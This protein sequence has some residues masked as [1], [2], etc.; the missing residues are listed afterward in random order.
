M[1]I[2][3]GGS[4]AASFFARPNVHRKTCSLLSVNGCKAPVLR[5]ASTLQLT[6][7]L[8]DFGCITCSDGNFAGKDHVQHVNECVSR[9]VCQ[10]SQHGQLLGVNLKIAICGRNPGS[11]PEHAKV[12]E[13]TSAQADR[14]IE[15]RPLHDMPRAL[16]ELGQQND[17]CRLSI[18][19][20]SGDTHW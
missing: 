17:A 12:D 3:V 19:C 18:G 20:T 2:P 1:A 7:N 10:F 11:T 5:S 14:E 8:F 16:T 6:L 13:N 15:R 4:T 9:D